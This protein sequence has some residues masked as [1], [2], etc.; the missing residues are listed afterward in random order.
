MEKKNGPWTIKETEKKF[1]SDFFSV[2]EDKVIQPDGK[3]G[4][5]ATINLKNG[6]CVLPLDDEGFVYITKQFKYAFGR[7]S[8]EVAAG[9]IEDGEEPSN[10]VKREAEE[11]LG[12]KAE[13]LI[14]LGKIDTDTSIIKHQV[15]LFLAKNL[16]FREP[17]RE[18]TEEIKTLKIKLDDAVQ[19]VMDGEITHAPSCILILKAYF[20][21]KNGE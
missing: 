12:I 13:E 4:S 6:V 21:V 10:S 3:D 2:F 15:H 7:D 16:N 5:Y 19:K 17:N 14:D 11:E 18:A 1:E 9:A 20:R 8:L